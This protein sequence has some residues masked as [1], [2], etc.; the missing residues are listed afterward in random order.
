[1]LKM[2]QLALV[3]VEHHL[4]LI[5]MRTKLTLQDQENLQQFLEQ[6]LQL[7]QE[8]KERYTELEQR[9]R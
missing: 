6:I 3:D 9:I 5:N 7:S 4:A 1:M 2:L 8:A